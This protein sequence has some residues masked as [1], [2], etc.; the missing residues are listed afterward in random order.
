MSPKKLVSSVNKAK[1]SP[2]DVQLA[3]LRIADIVVEHP[4]SLSPVV[5]IKLFNPGATVAFLTEISAIVLER[6][7]YAALVKPSAN[8]DLLIDTKR[9]VLKVAHE[10]PPNKTERITIRLGAAPHNLACYFRLQLE[11]TYNGEQVLVSEPFEVEFI[12]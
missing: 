9:N 4:K 11:F 7:P 3:T 5:D 8:Y 6:V 12:E 2:S 1:E 10:I